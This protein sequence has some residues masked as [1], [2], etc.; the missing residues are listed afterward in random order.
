MV[1][2]PLMALLM[3]LVYAHD[4]LLAALCGFNLNVDKLAYHAH[5]YL[6]GV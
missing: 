5:M 4:A 1:K 6:V 3:M 2:P